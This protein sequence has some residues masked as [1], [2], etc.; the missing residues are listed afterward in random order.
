MFQLP[1]KTLLASLA[2]AGSLL[3]IG[4]ES[5]DTS[6]NAAALAAMKTFHME[7]VGGGLTNFTTRNPQDVTVLTQEAVARELEQKGY[8]E[9]P[10]NDPADFSVYPGW[11]FYQERDRSI[12]M[13]EPINYDQTLQ[14]KNTM[15]MARLGVRIVGSDGA[16]LWNS[17]AS[18]GIQANL[19]TASDFTQAAGLALSGFPQSMVAT[20]APAATMPPPPPVPDE[21]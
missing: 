7:N 16:E 2:A 18:W 15:T 10:L 8:R 19:N 13:S 5:T 12:Q 17:T 3:F 21:K 1:P 11:F 14:L 6:E 9:V 4:C 20:S